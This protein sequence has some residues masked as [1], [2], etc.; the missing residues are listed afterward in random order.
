MNLN[1]SRFLALL[2]LPLL[3]H[4]AS[5]PTPAYSPDRPLRE[6][7]T[8]LM[9]WHDLARDRDIP[10]K[11]YYPANAKSPCP[12]IIFSHGLGGTREGYAYLGEHWAGCGYISVHLQHI[13]S[14]DAVWRGAG[15]AAY[16]Q[17]TRAVNDPVNALNRAKDVTFA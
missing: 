11:I 14:D 17:L 15:V 3:C 6:V 5:S 12:L 9:T 7:A 13:G 2:L 8:L 10:V 4:A 16:A 1:P